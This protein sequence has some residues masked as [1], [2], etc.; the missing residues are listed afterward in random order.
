MTMR[1]LL[2][3]DRHRISFEDNSVYCWT[4]GRFPISSTDQVRRSW[5]AINTGRNISLARSSQELLKDWTKIR[6]AI[7]DA[8]KRLVD[9][10]G[11]PVDGETT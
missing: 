9:A 7:L 10:N 6:D 1:E 3:T 8:Y 2:E 5:H 11:P 4:F